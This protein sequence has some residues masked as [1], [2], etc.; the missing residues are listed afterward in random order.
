MP[1]YALDFNEKLTKIST[2][3]GKAPASYSTLF[4]QGGI[5]VLWWQ[6]DGHDRTVIHLDVL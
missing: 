1:A 3:A 6:T 2:V 5:V 4:I